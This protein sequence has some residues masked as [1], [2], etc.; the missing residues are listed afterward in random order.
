MSEGNHSPPGLEVKKI[1]GGRKAKEHL[2]DTFHCTLP[3]E[4]SGWVPGL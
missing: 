1:G 3:S 2:T 4:A